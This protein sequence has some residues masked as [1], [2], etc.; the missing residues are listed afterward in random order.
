MFSAESCSFLSQ[1][2]TGHVLWTKHE[3]KLEFVA[4][5]FQ[6]LADCEELQLSFDEVEREQML[7]SDPNR[8][9]ILPPI[10]KRCDWEKHFIL[11]TI[12]KHIHHSICVESVAFAGYLYVYTLVLWEMVLLGG[13]WPFARFKDTLDYESDYT[14][15]IKTPGNSRL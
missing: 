12:S 13:R 14:L 5:E 6:I 7:Q 11:L 9:E 2:M 1:D 4:F 8:E 3:V 15:R 10:S